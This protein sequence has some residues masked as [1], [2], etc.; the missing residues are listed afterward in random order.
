M[1]MGGV[2]AAGELPPYSKASHLMDSLIQS[3][4]GDI[5]VDTDCLCLCDSQ[6]LMKTQYPCLTD[7]SSQTF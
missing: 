6:H 3:P 4:M 2:H 5:W 1:M 7:R